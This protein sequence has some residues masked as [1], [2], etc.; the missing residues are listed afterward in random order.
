MYLRDFEVVLFLS[1][2]QETYVVV[3]ACQNRKLVLLER[4]QILL[5][6]QL[7]VDYLVVS[8]SI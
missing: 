7:A 6:E 1:S 4:L 2:V 8:N 5:S 3:S